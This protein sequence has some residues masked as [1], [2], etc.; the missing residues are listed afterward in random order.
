MQ[1]ERMKRVTGQKAGI[2]EERR[3]LTSMSLSAILTGRGGRSLRE[4]RPVTCWQ[5]SK[6]H[7]LST[8]LEWTP[9]LWGCEVASIKQPT[10]LH[11][12]LT[13]GCRNH[14][15]NCALANEKDGNISRWR[16]KK[17]KSI[18]K[19]TNT[20]FGSSEMCLRTN[21]KLGY[22][23]I[24]ATIHPKHCSFFGKVS[25]LSSAMNLTWTHVGVN[26]LVINKG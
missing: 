24:A 9:R 23:G 19:Q 1:T 25:I 2:N 12:L 13:K 16:K 8:K 14:V 5:K 22:L 18:T 15:N 11:I 7:T 17:I 20:G 4:S 6:A 21:N 26:H 3:E 10:R